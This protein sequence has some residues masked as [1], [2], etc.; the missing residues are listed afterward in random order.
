[1]SE[2]VRPYFSKL[3]NT[4]II[5]GLISFSLQL[6]RLIYVIFRIHTNFGFIEDFDKVGYHFSKG[7]DWSVSDSG[8]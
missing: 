7:F 5:M 8:I 3:Y 2:K 6:C 1:M 4:L